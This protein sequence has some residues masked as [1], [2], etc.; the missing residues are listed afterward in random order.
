MGQ[1]VYKVF[2]RLTMIPSTLSYFN[3][4]L[5]EQKDIPKDEPE[6]ARIQFNIMKLDSSPSSRSAGKSL[7]RRI[8]KNLVAAELQDIADECDENSLDSF[9]DS[10][11]DSELE[12]QFEDEHSTPSTSITLGDFIPSASSTGEPFIFLPAKRD[13]PLLSQESSEKMHPKGL[14]PPQLIDISEATQQKCIFDVF[15]INRFQ[16][17][18]FNL[19]EQ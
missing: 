17:K 9:S 7:R 14:A 12:E 4:A 15:E 1:V 3:A 2:I 8:R 11:S 5:R 18:P 13:K 16:L 10:D 19:H 6:A